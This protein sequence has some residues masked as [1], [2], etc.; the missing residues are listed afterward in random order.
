MTFAQLMEKKGT[1]NRV[2]RFCCSYLKE[3]KILDK[4]II[5]VRR[6]ES[7][8][9]AKRYTEPTQCRVY[10]KG[11]RVEQI[12]PILDWTLNDI[13]EFAKDRKITFAPVYYD[14]NG[15]FQPTRRLG[16]ICCP[17]QSSKSRIEEFKKYPNMVKL[18]LNAIQKYK[19]AHPNSNI[20]KYSKYEI[21]VQD[22][23]YN[24]RGQFQ[25]INAVDLFGNKPDWK[26][27]LER[28]FN[29]KL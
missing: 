5:G 28:Q 20:S 23:F 15:A 29:I 4:C 18:Y 3:Y 22:L 2:R 27:F 7:A 26:E 1:P 19:E 11:E 17:L 10:S 16:C 14:E 9:R 21:F 13:V 8:K 6:E 24:K 12:L 25:I